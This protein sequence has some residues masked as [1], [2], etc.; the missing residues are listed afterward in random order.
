MV[1]VIGGMDILNWRKIVVYRSRDKDDWVKARNLLESN[2][3]EYT[4]FESEEAQIAGCCSNLNPGNIWGTKKQ[5]IFRI[6]VP[7]KYK[8]QALTIL[9]GNVLPIKACGFQL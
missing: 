9:E 3:I 6:E 4:A 7:V 1:L 2:G 5:Y 8:E